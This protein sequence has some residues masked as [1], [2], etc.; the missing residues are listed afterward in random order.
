MIK[1][2]IA[3]DN[4]T[5]Y[6]VCMNCYGTLNLLGKLVLDNNIDNLALYPTNGQIFLYDDNIVN[7]LNNLNL[8]TNVSDGVNRLKY[9]TK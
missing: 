6:D 5:I 7:V 2:F 3:I 9:A 8:N 4:S 1:E